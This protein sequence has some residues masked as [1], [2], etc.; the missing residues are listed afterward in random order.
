MKI[1]FYLLL[2]LNF[3]LPQASKASS[4][5]NYQQI[6]SFSAGIFNPASA[7]ISKGSYVFNYDADSTHTA[8]FE[9]GGATRLFWV[10]GAIYLN[11]N[12]TYMRFKG[13]FAPYTI[14]P[15]LLSDVKANASDLSVNLFGLDT[16]ITHAWEWFPIHWIIPFLEAGYTYTFYSQFGS[17]DFDSVQGG[18]GNPTAGAGIRFWLNPS[19]SVR[20][21]DTQSYFSIPVF[22]T[23][24]WNQ[25]FSNGEPLDLAYSGL[26]FSASFGL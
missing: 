12:L 5:A 3:L 10:G 9:V 22:L 23:L 16:R 24:K 19:A 11:T 6:I 1:A 21:D 18:T 26:I 8:I 20:S 25:I 2:A 15:L 7:S 13:S 14:Q 17:S 4:D